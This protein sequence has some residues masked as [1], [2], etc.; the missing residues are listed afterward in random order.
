MQRGA[1]VLMGGKVRDRYAGKEV[2][3]RAA[4]GVAGLGIED[5][6]STRCFIACACTCMHLLS[7]RLSLGCVSAGCVHVS[8]S[9]KGV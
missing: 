8:V 1:E 3:A 7:Q 4:T 9:R 6:G 5:C 2:V